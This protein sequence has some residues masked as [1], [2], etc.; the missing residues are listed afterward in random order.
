VIDPEIV[1]NLFDSLSRES[2]RREHI[3]ADDWWNSLRHDQRR[4]LYLYF[5]AFANNS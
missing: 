4:A 2:E 5:K 1:T 3:E